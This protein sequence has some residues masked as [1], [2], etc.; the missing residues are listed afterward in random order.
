MTWQKLLLNLLEIVQDFVWTW[1]AI[2]AHEHCVG[3]NYQ[4]INARFATM[5]F[6]QHTNRMEDKLVSSVKAK[7][8]NPLS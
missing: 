1:A 3:I 7:V 5:E 4:P 2:I 6:P 8:L